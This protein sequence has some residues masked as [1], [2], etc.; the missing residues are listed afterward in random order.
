MDNINNHPLSERRIIIV[1][2]HASFFFIGDSD[3]EQIYWKWP[4]LTQLLSNSKLSGSTRHNFDSSKRSQNLPCTESP[5]T[6]QSSITSSQQSTE[7]RRNTWWTSLSNHQKGTST[8][9]W[10]RDFS[11][12]SHPTGTNG[13][14]NFSTWEVLCSV[15]EMQNLPAS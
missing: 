1:L 3:L 11:R 14:L 12:N 4:K 5:A 6:R 15:L 9:P 10:R 8:K 2:N 7:K 13:K